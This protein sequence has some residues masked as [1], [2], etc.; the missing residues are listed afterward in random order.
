MLER[1]IYALGPNVH[2]VSVQGGPHA[3]TEAYLFFLGSGYQKKLI[4][5]PLFDFAFSHN[6]FNALRQVSFEF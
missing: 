3:L 5:Y 1:I 6:A 4:E 2:V